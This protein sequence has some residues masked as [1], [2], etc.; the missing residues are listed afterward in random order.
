MKITLDKNCI[1]LS[2][3]AYAKEMCREWS[4]ISPDDIKTF[5][6]E[7]IKKYTGKDYFFGEL[8]SPGR[9]ELS[10]DNFK[11]DV[12]VEGCVLK[13]DYPFCTIYTVSGNFSGWY[14]GAGSACRVDKYRQS[15]SELVTV[16]QG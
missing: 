13:E 1:T 3:K 5:A 4:W 9:I 11:L 8:I 15:A 12:F 14:S 7:A 2:E 10:K 6:T 16:C